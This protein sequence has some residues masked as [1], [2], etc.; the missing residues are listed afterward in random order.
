MQYN[1]VTR[2]N[3][4]KRINETNKKK[5]YTYKLDTLY[6][7]SVCLCVRCNYPYTLPA[8]KLD[9][10]SSFP[11]LNQMDFYFNVA[12]SDKT[13]CSTPMELPCANFI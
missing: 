7:D 2:I 1:K 8:A 13:R 6:N 12:S 9:F 3:H 10:L 11:R 4:K 5:I